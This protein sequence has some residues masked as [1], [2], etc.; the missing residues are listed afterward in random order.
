MILAGTIDSQ[1][2][3]PTFLA[4]FLTAMLLALAITSRRHP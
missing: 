2:L 3:G 4:G 1:W